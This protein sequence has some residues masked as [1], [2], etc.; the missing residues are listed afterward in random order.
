MS[1]LHFSAQTQSQGL[2]NATETLRFRSLLLPILNSDLTS[3]L[4]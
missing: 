2:T 4:S 1:S 3:V